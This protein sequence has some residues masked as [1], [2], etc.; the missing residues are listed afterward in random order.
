MNSKLFDNC[1]PKSSIPCSNAVATPDSHAFYE[2]I[3]ESKNGKYS[4]ECTISKCAEGFEYNNVTNACNPCQPGYYKAETSSGYATVNVQF[5]DSDSCLRC[6]N[7]D[8]IMKEKDT[9][10]FLTYGYADDFKIPITNP[11]CP[12]V[13]FIFFIFSI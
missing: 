11:N 13:Y 5:G 6:D 12:W 4:E 9:S 3:C 1:A 7:F 2:R 10:F 8:A